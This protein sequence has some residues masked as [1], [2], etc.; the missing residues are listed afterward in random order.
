MEEKKTDWR[1]VVFFLV[2][3]LASPLIEGGETYHTVIWLRLWVIGFGLAFF[4]AAVKD[5]RL[6]LALP[7]ANFL[8]GLIILLLALSLFITHYYYITVYWSSNFLVYFLLG[9]LCLNVFA[10]KNG[11]KTIAAV[12]LIMLIAGTLESVYGVIEHFRIEEF[13]LR[14]EGTFFNTAYYAGY[15]AALVSFPL[16]GC[17]FNAFPQR[18]RG[19]EILVRASLGLLAGLFFLA[20]VLSASRA[21]IF[22]AVPIGLVLLARFRAKALI[23][24]LAL[25]LT[26]VI[27]PNPLKRRMQNLDRDPY[28]WERITIWKTSL[29]MIRRHP[30]GVGLGMYQYYY[31][32]YAYPLR[33]VKIGRFAKEARFAHN[34][35]LNLA[36]EASPLLPA[37]GLI[38]LGIA[39]SGL[40]ALIWRREKQ[41]R[42]RVFMLAFSG[43]LLAMLAHALA[44]DNLRQPPLTVLAAVDVAAMLCLAS[45]WQKGALRR[46]VFPVANSRFL[47]GFVLAAG[48]AMAAVLTWQALI[49][50][51]SLRAMAVRDLREKIARMEKLASLPGGYAPL[52]AGLASAY[53]RLFMQERRPA[54]AEA[55]LNYYERATTLNP[56][57]REYYF[58][59]AEFLYSLGVRLPSEELLRQAEVIA[60]KGFERANKDVFICLM[61][62][63]IGRRQKD[64]Q[65]QEKW[66]KIALEA[67]PYFL[68]GRLRLA[69]L[70]AGQGKTSEARAELATL[71]SQKKE[72]DLIFAN[73][74]EWRLNS[75]QKEL[76]ELD[77]ADLERL[78]GRFGIRP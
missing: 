25:T 21:I 51:L 44:D 26:L 38:W 20:M 32:R 65:E 52:Q 33:T 29:R 55:A 77:A 17:V 47:R 78:R 75:L 18:S 34:A 3:I 42:E 68:A 67:E 39:F 54:Q 49:F 23:A 43:S 66:L 30:A 1:W 50:G 19:R 59:W 48:L 31:N 4:L 14:P 41:S 15:L 58:Q 71:E 8:L 9:Y 53:G 46:K 12:Y 37:A 73:K 62:A 64:F 74:E 2:L 36:A 56:E 63:D 16:A 40:P 6:E 45:V 7:A 69:E 13:Y 22:A 35:Y 5:D 60:K 28:T 27:A 57:S 24:L 76:V 11:G 10:K 70:Y 72:A 61:L